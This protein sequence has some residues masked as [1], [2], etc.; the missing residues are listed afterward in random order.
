MLSELAMK[1]ET[2]VWSFAINDAVRGQTRGGTTTDENVR[3]YV[4]N[5]RSLSVDKWNNG[6]SQDP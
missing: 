3:K 4:V 5:S 2:D 1:Y 6:N